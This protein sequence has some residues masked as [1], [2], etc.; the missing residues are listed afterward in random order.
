LG[1]KNHALFS[2]VVFTNN[3]ILIFAFNDH[4]KV[5]ATNTICVLPENSSMNFLQMW[6]LEADPNIL[7]NK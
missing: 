2:F 5:K 1:L 7:F 3:S 4:K 6:R